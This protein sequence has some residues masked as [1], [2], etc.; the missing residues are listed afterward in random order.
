MSTTVIQ[1]TSTIV[2]DNISSITI[3]G[4][5]LGPTGPAS[6]VPGPTGPTGAAGAGGTLGYYGSFYSNQTQTAV[7]VD[8]PYAMT[9]NSSYESNGI[10]VVDNSKITANL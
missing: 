7:A 10:S 1:N 2:V 6:I 3:P 8:T 5:M 9:L 4:G